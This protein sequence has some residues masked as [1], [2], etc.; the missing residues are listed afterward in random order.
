MLKPFLIRD[1][2]DDPLS[3]PI[4]DDSES[5]L[6]NATDVG[7]VGPQQRHGLVQLSAADYDEISYIHPQARLTY[8]DDD[9]GETITVGSSLELT[10]RLDEPAPRITDVGS[11]EPMHLFDIRQSNSVTD[12]WKRFE[13]HER[14]GS[15]ETSNPVFELDN[16][17]E[18]A[19]KP[20]PNT[21]R[22]ESSRM[23]NERTD[24]ATNDASDSFLSAF[25]AELAKVMI[26]SHSPAEND[27][28]ESTSSSR[29]PQAES[30]FNIPR[31]T[32]QAFASALRNLIEV[33]ELISS[34]VKSK[35]PEL[36]GHLENA[37]RSL[38][39]DMTDSMRNAFLVLEEQVK[40]M[41]TALNNLPETIRRENRPGGAVHF[42]DFPIPFTAVR[43]LREMGVQLGDIGQTLLDT[44]ESSVRGAF[45]G[46]QNSYFP[47]F[48]GFSET[49][50]QQTT[51]PDDLAG[52]SSAPHDSTT[53][54][55][56]TGS[57]NPQPAF[58]P[59]GSVVVPMGAFSPQPLIT[60]S[61][62]TDQR[63]SLGP[64]SQQFRRPLSIPSPYLPTPFP[65]RHA[66]P[67]AIPSSAVPSS[68]VPP[69]ET[70]PFWGRRG[71]HHLFGP[72]PMSPPYEPT[73][74]SPKYHEP[75]NASDSTWQSRPRDALPFERFSP[76]SQTPQSL[77][78]GNIGFN[79]TERMIR[80][81]FTSKGFALD[82]NLPMDTRT[83]EHAGFGY[84]VFHSPADAARALRDVQGMI[85]DGHC[86]NLEYLDHAPITTVMPLNQAGESVPA[87][88]SSQTSGD[89]RRDTVNPVTDSFTDSLAYRPDIN[90]NFPQS[91]RMSNSSSEVVHDMLLAQTE[92]RFP[93]VSQLDA[94]MLSS[95]SSGAKPPASSRTAKNASNSGEVLGPTLRESFGSPE[96][97]PGSFPQDTHDD[98]ILGSSANP[99]PPIT[100]PHSSRPQHDARTAAWNDYHLTENG[101]KELRN[102]MNAVL[103]S[104]QSLHAQQVNTEDHRPRH[105]HHNPHSHVFPRRAATVM[106][107]GPLRRPLDP[108]EASR[109]LRR[110][111]TEQH[112]LRS[113]PTLG[114]HGP[115]HRTSYY[116]SQPMPSEPG[117]MSAEEPSRRAHRKNSQ[118]HHSIEDCV[119][120]LAQLGYGIEED[121]GLQRLE[122]YAAAANGEL[123]DAIEIIEEE[124]K[125]YEQRG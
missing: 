50:N 109:A 48:P 9:D 26:A 56:A 67:S 110:R 122:I 29:A 42:P 19:T 95:Q 52:D 24:T 81:V 125:A 111:A 85:I 105:P 78:I 6:Y 11:L 117:N 13:Q 46:Y 14:V 66:S 40:A 84:L 71:S 32:T 76:G 74:E 82:V 54:G 69:S 118:K 31:D 73:Y 28:T 72:S 55:S 5:D 61:T 15:L 90:T 87:T 114:P 20:D 108:S 68:A 92:A 60:S 63:H 115:R 91:S 41:A 7:S 123:A 75:F 8:L 107:V 37:R 65:I 77:F 34:G 4:V 98:P 96:T 103:E 36:E 45:P 113:G 21:T 94:H 120:A 12:L 39:R 30:T 51:T 10:Q 97:L 38:P 104:R 33:A 124:R 121:G 88:T 17:Q 44:F 70:P 80:D 3:Q 16:L 93:P 106:S 53:S 83:S 47:N 43:G 35:L 59:Q 112:S 23:E 25:E 27:T 79:V 49:N 64:L 89:V 22:E 58:P 99:S 62:V 2:H 100:R 86:I 119:A 102:D 1:L 116:A 57:G 101:N 18:S